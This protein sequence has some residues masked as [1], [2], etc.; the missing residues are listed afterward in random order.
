M[1]AW[2]RATVEIGPFH[3]QLASTFGPG[4]TQ[5]ALP[6]FGQLVA[7]THEA[8][9]RLTATLQNVDVAALTDRLRTGTLEDLVAEVQRDGMHRA[10]R[11]GLRLLGVAMAAALVIALL[12]FRKNWR[13]V[14]AALATAFVV[15]AG[16]EG[17][18]VENLQA[19]PLLAPTLAQF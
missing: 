14:V 11:F 10:I 8:P 15:T 13:Q 5:I 18:T 7:D 19:S 4:R 6:P 2:G 12:V 3:V 17:T 9:L 1:L 16:G